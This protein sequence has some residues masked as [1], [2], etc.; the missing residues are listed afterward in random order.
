M[1]GLSTMR[2]GLMAGGFCLALAALAP[3]GAGAQTPLVLYTAYENG[4]MKPLIDAFEK[5]NPGL[6]ISHFHQPGEELVATLELELR[7]GSPKA[8]AV[9]LNDASLNYLQTRHSAFEPYAAKGVEKVK[10]ELQNKAHIFTPAFVNLYLI[11]YNT[12]K[13][14]AADAPKSWADLTDPKWKGQIALADPA[15][16][17]SVQSFIWFIADHLGKTD[18]AKF[19]WDY[20]KRLAANEPRLESSHGTIRDLT[21][22][23]ERPVAVQLLANAQTAANRGEPTSNV[24]PTE[25]APGELSAFAVVKGAKNAAGAKLWLDFLLSPEGQALMPKSLGGAPVRTDVAYKYPDG[26]P[27]DQV[28]IVPVDSAFISANRKAQAKKFHDAIGR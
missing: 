4:Q 11:H 23:G 25:G 17:Q 12:K 9:G 14:T 1:A 28:R 16:S 20:F 22:S 6:K 13:I 24:W 7:A 2:R 5:Q 19:G 21:V 27:L 15:S 10:A 26:T 18:P 8:D 3:A